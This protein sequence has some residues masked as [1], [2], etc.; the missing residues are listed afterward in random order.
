MKTNKYRKG[1][2]AALLVIIMLLVWPGI[3]YF[4]K[5]SI[6]SI[7]TPVE[8]ISSDIARKT[9][10]SADLFRS[11]TGGTDREKQL[12]LKLV[13]AQSELNRLRYIELENKKLRKALGF[14]RVNP[15]SLIPAT[16]LSRN[17]S[18][19]WNTIRI[20]PG[21]NKGISPDCAVVSPDGLVGKIYQVNKSSCEVLLL[22][23]PTFRVAARLTDY[24][25][26]GIVRGMG[27]SLN[28]QP[29]VRMEFINKN[30]NIKIGDEV[31]TSGFMQ[32][33]HFFPSGVHIGYIEK[34]YEDESGLF[35][36]AEIIP[37]ATSGILDFLFIASKKDDK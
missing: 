11:F 18:G 26:F 30:I 35:Q 32:D 19:W 9:T 22:S 2:F 31:T 6:R 27:N 4:S 29:L 1:I 24:E 14:E 28:G 33:D 13:Q 7:S 25:V 36:H 8:I 10:S 17:I 12:S 34:V 15:Y 20:E 23:D 37:R 5:K 21:A 16:V 3:T